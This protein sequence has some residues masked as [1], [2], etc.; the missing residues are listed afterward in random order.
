MPP[1]S[2]AGL[3]RRADQTQEVHDRQHPPAEEQPKHR[4][5]HRAAAATLQA[6][7][8]GVGRLPGMAA[9]SASTVPDMARQA[10]RAGQI[11]F[12]QAPS[13]IWIVRNAIRKAGTFTSGKAMTQAHATP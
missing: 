9:R 4:C 11:A 12:T 1:A 5:I 6:A 2:L 8:T 7:A 13:P 10:A 3:S